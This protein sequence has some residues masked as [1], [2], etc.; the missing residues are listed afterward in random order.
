MSQ[1]E[2]KWLIEE[3]NS[4]LGSPYF[5]I[6]S[7]FYL[8][9]N[10]L[11]LAFQVCKSGLKV[12]PESIEGNFIMAQIH[13]LNNNLNEAEKILKFVVKRHPAHVNAWKLLFQIQNDLRRSKKSIK[14]IATSLLKINPNDNECLI[15]LQNFVKPKEVISEEKVSENLSQKPTKKEPEVITIP[16]EII[17]ISKR[18]A[19]FTLAEIYQKQGYFYQAIEVLKVVEQKGGNR[20]RLKNIRN[21]I[22]EAIKLQMEEGID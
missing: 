11:D 17:P 8:K 4:N 3:V 5:P 13:I 16:E 10:E 22:D 9:N 7:H 15:W 14:S 19:S 21:Q 1:F 12:V 18:M 6:L 2:K 20:R